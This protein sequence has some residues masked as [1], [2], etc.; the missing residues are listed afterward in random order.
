MIEFFH[1]IIHGSPAHGRFC[2]HFSW[3][4]GFIHGV[5]WNDGLAL[6]MGHSCIEPM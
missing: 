4:N 5:P 1:H 3:I 6:K 2:N